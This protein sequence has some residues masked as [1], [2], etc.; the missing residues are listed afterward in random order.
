MRS[1]R[2]LAELLVVGDLLGELPRFRLARQVVVRHRD[3]EPRRGDLPPPF[4]DV[5]LAPRDLARLAR[6]RIVRRLNRRDLLAVRLCRSPS[7]Q[8]GGLEQH[9]GGR[10]PTL[11]AP[12]A[13]RR[14]RRRSRSRSDCACA[15][16]S[17]FAR[18]TLELLPAVGD[19]AG[20]LGHL[21]VDQQL[22]RRL[23]VD[24]GLLVVFELAFV[25]RPPVARVADEP[26]L[27]QSA[28]SV[29]GDR[30]DRCGPRYVN[31]RAL[32]SIA[33]TACGS[34]SSVWL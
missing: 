11:A 8:R 9:V 20:Q 1:A 27:A 31:A 34:S 30:L 2:P 23:D 22:R 16:R 21:R 33:S 10:V 19:E 26:A 17:N 18:D 29:G 5:L 32:P 12:P 4:G 7:R 24:P 6:R 14:D 25:E 3:V 13:R 28:A 15:I